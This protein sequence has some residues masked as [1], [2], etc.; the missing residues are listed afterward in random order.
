ME[1]ST[2]IMIVMFFVSLVAGVLGIVHIAQKLAKRKNVSE[3]PSITP[4]PRKLPEG[5]DN[6]KKREDWF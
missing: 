6:L 1:T 4:L 2:V 3:N 5:E